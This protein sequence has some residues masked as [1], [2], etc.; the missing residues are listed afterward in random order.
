[1]KITF[2]I[3]LI[4][5]NFCLQLQ[6]FLL[7]GYNIFVLNLTLHHFSCMCNSTYSLK[8]RHYRYFVF[9]VNGKN[10]YK[11]FYD[12]HKREMSFIKSCSTSFDITFDI[13]RLMKKLLCFNI[14][15]NCGNKL[16]KD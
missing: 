12:K 8:L 5:Q 9:V 7:T 3:R 11:K 6:T 14:C 2:E 15:Q 13:F 10:E 16:I 4:L 1:M